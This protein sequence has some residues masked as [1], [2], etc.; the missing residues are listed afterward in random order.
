[1]DHYLYDSLSEEKIKN[2][3]KSRRDERQLSRL[4]WFGVL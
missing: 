2:K 1:M 4:G 3:K